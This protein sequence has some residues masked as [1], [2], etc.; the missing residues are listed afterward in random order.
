MARSDGIVERQG[1]LHFFSY[2]LMD[3]IVI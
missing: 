2:Y 1:D 3:G